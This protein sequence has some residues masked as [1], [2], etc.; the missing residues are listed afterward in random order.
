VSSEI[1][2]R[3]RGSHRTHLTWD[4]DSPGVAPGHA[5][6]SN[7]RLWPN[8]EAPVFQTG[9]RGGSTRQTLHFR[10][11]GRAERHPSSKRIHAGAVPAGSTNQSF[12]DDVKV[13][14][15]PVKRLVVV[16]V[17]VGE[18]FYSARMVQKQHAWVS[19]RKPRRDTGCGCHFS[20]CSSKAEH[21]ADNRETVGRY[22]AQG[23]FIK[24]A[25]DN[26]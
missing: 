10:S 9:P 14:W 23:P 20:L 4:Q 3:V 11:R 22:H 24:P 25:W 2:N 7:M 6:I 16:R 21:A 12:P 8:S 1:L 5:T 26:S 13:A 19:T 15:P 17:H 18:P